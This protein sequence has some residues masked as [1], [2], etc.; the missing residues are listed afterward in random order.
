MGDSADKCLK[1]V[2][3]EHAFCSD[4]ELN[5]TCQHKESLPKVMRCCSDAIEFYFANQNYKN[6]PW[7]GSY[8]DQPMWLMQLSGIVAKVKKEVDEEKSKKVSNGNR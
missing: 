6:Y 4:C 5:E 8:R 2:Q 7:S 1:G 3:G